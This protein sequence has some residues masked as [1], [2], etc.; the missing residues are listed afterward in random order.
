MKH[1]LILLSASS[2]LFASG[3]ACLQPATTANGE[4]AR[5][6]CLA[7]KEHN[8][9]LNHRLASK[10]PARRAV[11]DSDETVAIVV[12]VVETMGE[13]A[14]KPTNKARVLSESEAKAELK[15]LKREGRIVSY[16]RMLT[17]SGNPVSFRSVINQPILESA[18]SSPDQDGGETSTKAEIEYI[19]IGTLIGARPTLLANDKIHLDLDMTL[20]DILGTEFYQGN[21]Y[22]AVASRH[23]TGTYQL[24]EGETVFLEMPAADGEDTTLKLFATA[25]A[26]PSF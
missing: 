4:S 7:L 15:E 20:S 17:E 26:V 18:S 19:P 10:P 22:P 11:M 23:H 14:A 25:A 5:A 6:E 9:A 2:L 16:P 8:E 24:A 21:P 3:C 13:K 1:S 12:T